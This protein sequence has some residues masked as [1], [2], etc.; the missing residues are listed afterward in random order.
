M[1]RPRGPKDEVTM[2]TVHEDE[3]LDVVQRRFDA[4]IDRYLPYLGLV[5]G[6]A[7][8]PLGVDTDP[9]FWLVTGG[10]VAASGAWS[11]WFTTRR[12]VRAA[13]PRAGAVYVTGLLALMAALM[14]Q[15]PLYCFQAFA[16]YV[17]AIA[18]LRG[19]WR[20]LGVGVT[21]VL[22]AYGLVGGR[23][24]EFDTT[25]VLAL[26][27]LAVVN[28]A[29]GGGF[30]WFG[31]LT[32][33]QSERR[34]QVIAELEQA[35]RRLSVALEENAGLHVQLLAQAREA[36]VLDE[37]ARMAREIH[38][39]L[40]QALTAI[41]TQL[42]AVDAAEARP[43]QRRRHVDTARTLAREGL[44]EAR[45]SVQALAPEPLEHVRL[46]DAITDLAESWGETSGVA[47]TV[48]STGT[49]VPLLAELEVT[50][51]RV[52]QE[53][54]TNISKHAAASTVGL[55]LSY[56]DLVVVLDV[57]DDGVGFAADRSEP[58]DG[59]GF[60]LR[61]MRQRVQRAGGVLEIESAPGEG[62]AVSASVPA[63]STA[64]DMR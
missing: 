21:A 10:L 60:G 24:A 39:T 17:G 12:P 43:E 54:L 30:T 58:G 4:A 31:A 50:L 44:A 16:G 62:T 51:F 15:S 41:V 19:H 36:G 7:L 22:T 2:T 64:G 27:V 14:F 63:I 20:W 6:T 46:P 42:E 3:R 59:S 25:L 48:A 8:T 38:D 28:A 23:T 13:E 18:F 40:A 26:V 33:R 5:I 55:T 32:S 37:R 57:R 53:A 34:R 47:Y 52:A 1:A 45:R 11:Y 9:G 35:N 29:L 56:T 49:P 61:A